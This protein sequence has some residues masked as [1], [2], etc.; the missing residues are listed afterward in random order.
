MLVRLILAGI[1]V[2][3]SVHA[4]T[5]DVED[6]K[7]FYGLFCAQC[8]GD[9]GQGDGPLSGVLKIAPPNLTG[10]AARNGGTF[11]VQDVAMDIDGRDPTVA[12][13]GNMPTFG[14]FL[15]SDRQIPVRLP[16]GQTMLVG[17]TMAD[18]L[19][20]LETIQTQ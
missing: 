10:L 14:P 16:S 15:D 8:H 17:E 12:H 2:A 13:G 3:G 20:Y 4:Q 7:E 5:A 9:T 18:L 11:P 1:V 6:G 19:A